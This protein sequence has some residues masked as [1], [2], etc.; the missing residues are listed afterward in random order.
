MEI[1]LN[2]RICRN[3]EEILNA[4]TPEVAA[5][6]DEWFAP[7]DFVWGHTSGSTGTPKPVRLLKRDMEAS[8]RLTNDFF[9]ITCR[10]VM[11]LCLSPD[12]IAGKMMIVRAL[13]SG[14]DLLVVTPSSFDDNRRAYR[15][16]R[17]GSGASSRIFEKYDAEIKTFSYNV[18]D[19]R[20]CTF[21]SRY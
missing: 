21:I 15:F 14:A 7:S 6:L 12:Y 19:N 13:L 10:S 17:D 5:F 4:S 20:W 8:A 2:H 18:S 1:R 11:L 9:D 16:C 3:R